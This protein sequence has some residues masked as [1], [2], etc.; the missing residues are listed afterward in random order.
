MSEM[1]RNKCLKDHGCKVG[2][3]HFYAFI[4]F[5]NNPGCTAKQAAETLENDKTYD[6]E[7]GEKS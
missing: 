1:L 2:T 4:Y 5:M 6:H 3:A 7:V